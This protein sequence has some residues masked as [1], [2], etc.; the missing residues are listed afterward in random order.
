MEEIK[1][2]LFWNVYVL[3]HIAYNLL[4][5]ETK[6]SIFKIIIFILN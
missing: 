2:M 6:M 5:D 4:I 1:K 3:K